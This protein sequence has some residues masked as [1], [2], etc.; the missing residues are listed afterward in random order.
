VLNGLAVGRSC[1]NFTAVE[2]WLARPENA[3]RYEFIKAERQAIR[4]D[5]DIDIE[6]VYDGLMG[7]A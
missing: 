5:R 3:E 1:H 2:S 4:F 7:L 6:S